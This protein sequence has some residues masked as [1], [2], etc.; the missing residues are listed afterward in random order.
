MTARTALIVSCDRNLTRAVSQ[1]L[2]D[3]GLRVETAYDYPTAMG[4]I[5]DRLPALI[6]LDFAVP[7]PCQLGLCEMLE[8]DAAARDVPVL[9]FADAWDAATIA[10]TGGLCVYHLKRSPEMAARLRPF[11][12][13]LIDLGAP[14]TTPGY[15]PGS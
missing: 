4:L 10:R 7:S 1:T 15:T 13:E 11:V 3:L 6:C 9:G 8:T 5:D 12:E 14:V 2:Q